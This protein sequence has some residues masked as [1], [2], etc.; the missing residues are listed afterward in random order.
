MS[1]TP[2]TALPAWQLDDLYAGPDDPAIAAELAAA[3]DAAQRFE[4]DVK[5]R[6]ASLDGPALAAAI[7]RF[8]ALEDAMGRLAS[9]AQLLA[10]ADRSNAE[11]ARFQ[12][13]IQE[14]LTQTGLHLVFFQLE[15][16]R[17][18]D[19]A[20]A[21]LNAHPAMAR[22]RPWIDEVRAW[23][24]HRLDDATEARL[25]ELAPVLRQPWM[26]LFDQSVAE[27]RFQVGGESLTEARALDL[28]SSPDR[29][30]RREAALETL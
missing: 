13:S 20:M 8:E 2:P 5:G 28:L 10:A 22:W 17:I 27:L 15:L 6:L 11:N 18:D 24:R 14:R 26:R 12:Q 4:A 29:A 16:S 1:A 19:R 23:R 7:A 21:T 9:Y 30:R 25:E 3:D